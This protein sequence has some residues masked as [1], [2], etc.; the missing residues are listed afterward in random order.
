MIAGGTGASVA[1]SIAHQRLPSSEPTTVLWCADQDSEIYASEEL[2]QMVTELN[3]RVDN[4]R[5]EKNTG[6]M[7][8]ANN[9][10]PEHHQHVI[11]SGSPGFVYAVTDLLMEKGFVPSA[12]QSDV[13]EYAPR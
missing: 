4:R 5:T 7:W 3:V 8:L 9:A 13:Y 6:L 2:A 10:H 12:L 11:I 1:F